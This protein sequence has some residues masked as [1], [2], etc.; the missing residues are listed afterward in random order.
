MAFDTDYS[1]LY[2]SIYGTSY[3]SKH[4]DIFPR[5]I[6]MILAGS[7]NSG[8]T[9]LLINFIM[10]GSVK[11]D[12]IMIYTTTSY[13]DSYKFLGEYFDEVKSQLKLPKDI[14]TFYNPEEGIEDPSSLDKNKTHIVVFDDVM[15]E[16]QKV[17]KQ[18]TSLEVDTI[19]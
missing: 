18:T 7:T 11:Y 4:A 10:E 1:K 14:I 16:K 6:F 15:N 12:N 8:K 2:K 9:N 13:Q 5:N 19:M 17:T 3:E